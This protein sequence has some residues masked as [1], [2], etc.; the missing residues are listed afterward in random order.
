MLKTKNIDVNPKLKHLN[1]YLRKNHIIIV[2]A[3]LAY[4][5]LK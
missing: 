5:T 4:Q 2:L 1:I 3:F